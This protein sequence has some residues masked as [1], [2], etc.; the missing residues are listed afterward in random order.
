[1]IGTHPYGGQEVVDMLNRLGYRDRADEASRDL[2][3]PVDID[4][5]EEWCDQKAI[6]DPFHRTL[7]LVALIHDYASRI[8]AQRRLR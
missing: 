8:Q 3:N 4:Q 5:L 7:E 1:V 6:A 2:P